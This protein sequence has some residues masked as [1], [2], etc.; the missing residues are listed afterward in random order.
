MAT[1]GKETTP[2][3]QELL[4]KAGMQVDVTET[5]AKDLTDANLA[6]Y[7]VLLLN[8]KDTKKGAPSRSKKFPYPCFPN[9]EG[10]SVAGQESLPPGRISHY[11]EESSGQ[12][13]SLNCDR[14]DNRSERQGDYRSA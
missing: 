10:L 9:A 8:Y 11:K 2:F 1:T 14:E 6:R 3:L 4:T 5:P 12:V 13:A 7:D